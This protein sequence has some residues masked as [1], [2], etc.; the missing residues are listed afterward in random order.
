MVHH[1]GTNPD[2][3]ARHDAG[4]AA[5]RSG[6]TVGA[7]HTMYMIIYTIMYEKCPDHDRR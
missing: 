5:A 7:V 2:D 3:A 1:A 6:V 4:R